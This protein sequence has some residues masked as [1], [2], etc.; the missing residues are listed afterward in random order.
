MLRPPDPEIRRAALP[1]GP[2]RRTHE[3]SCTAESNAA[4]IELQARRLRNR[5]ALGYC[6]ACSLA[7]LLWGLPR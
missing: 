7:P 3:V 5:Y 4:V 2:V 1:G 6:L